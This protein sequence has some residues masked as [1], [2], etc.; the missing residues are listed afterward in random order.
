MKN[1]GARCFAHALL[2]LHDGSCHSLTLCVLSVHRHTRKYNNLPSYFP[3]S[4]K[5]AATPVEGSGKQKLR[6]ER[7]AALCAT[8]PPGAH[9]WDVVSTSKLNRPTPSHAAFIANG[10]R[11]RAEAAAHALGQ[12]SVLGGSTHVRTGLAQ[13][14]SELVRVLGAVDRA[15]LYEEQAGRRAAN[16]AT[17]QAHIT[18]AIGA[19]YKLL[20]ESSIEDALTET[21]PVA[22]PEAPSEPAIAAHHNTVHR[23]GALGAHGDS[24]PIEHSLN[25]GAGH[26]RAP[27]PVVRHRK[28]VSWDPRRTH[29]TPP[30]DP[31][32]APTRTALGGGG[33]K[34]GAE[35]GGGGG[36]PAAA[37]CLRPCSRHYRVRRSDARRAPQGRGPAPRAFTRHAR[38]RHAPPGHRHAV[39]PG[40]QA[41]LGCGSGVAGSGQSPRR[42]K[43]KEGGG[44]S[45]ARVNVIVTLGHVQMF[46][47]TL[48]DS[49]GQL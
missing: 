1:H 36:G 18:M 37:P 29:D 27:T 32:C 4:T 14:V 5:H 24:A 3:S 25:L 42:L 40:D 19:P 7:A 45:P 30:H 39:Q 49:P 8:L 23:R 6:A 16:D 9:P 31:R 13:D 41:G 11:A 2:P 28:E 26:I 21:K 17:F 15:V 43:R 33:G 44:P 35:R 10:V 46:R 20:A 22:R 48:S 34:E 12:C 38:A 47:S